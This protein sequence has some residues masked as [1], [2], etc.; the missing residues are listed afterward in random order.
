ML[1]KDNFVKY[2][3]QFYKIILGSDALRVKA[4]SQCSWGA[5]EAVNPLVGF[6]C[7]TLEG[8][9]SEALGTTTL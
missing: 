9:I 4:S 8:S 2:Q 1:H 6:W 3:W 5:R 7:T